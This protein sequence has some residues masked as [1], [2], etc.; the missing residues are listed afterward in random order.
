MDFECCQ[1]GEVR[2]TF[3][4]NWTLLTW[5]P[6]RARFQKGLISRRNSLLT[7]W[8]CISSLHKPMAAVQTVME[9]NAFLGNQSAE[10]AVSSNRDEY[11]LPDIFICTGANLRNFCPHRPTGGSSIT[12]IIITIRE[13]RCISRN[14]VNRTAT[15]NF[16][17]NISARTPELQSFI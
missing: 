4:L 1:D 2:C 7:P 14:L 16:S 10:A 5:T 12:H 3:R 13:T 15:A 17:E 8:T 6:L 11:Y 9:E